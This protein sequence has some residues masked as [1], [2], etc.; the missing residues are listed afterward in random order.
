MTRLYSKCLQCIAR[1][2]SHIYSPCSESTPFLQQQSWQ[3]SISAAPLLSM[4]SQYTISPARIHSVHH[5]L[6]TYPVRI[7]PFLPIDSQN[8][9]STT[10]VQSEYYL[11]CSLYIKIIMG[12]LTIIIWIF[13]VKVPIRIL[14]YKLYKHATPHENVDDLSFPMMYHTV[15]YTMYSI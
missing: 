14:I 10:H 7:P 12:N 3:N 15:V 9:T 13:T 4:S 5:I 2:Y 11:Y 8:P 6:Y 1:F